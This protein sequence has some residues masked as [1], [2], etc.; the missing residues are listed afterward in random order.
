MAEITGAEV[1]QATADRRAYQRGYAAGRKRVRLDRQREHLQRQE[2]AAWNRAFLAVLP[3]CIQANGWQDSNG[4]PI[5]TL[6][7]RV[8]LASN[9]ADQALKHMRLW[10]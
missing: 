4:K 5:T 8:Q 6:P 1:E 2:N 3:G 9:A 10:P 7:Q